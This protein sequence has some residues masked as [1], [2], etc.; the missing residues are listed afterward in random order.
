MGAWTMVV[1]GHGIHDNELENDSNEMFDKFVND[2]KV[3][4]HY[5][6]SAT[7]VAGSGREYKTGEYF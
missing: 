4:G 3:K 2:L 7:F 5:I 6:H 1:S